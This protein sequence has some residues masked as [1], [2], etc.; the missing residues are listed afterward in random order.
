MEWPRTPGRPKS[1]TE[2][3]W[4]WPV[5]E[6]TRNIRNFCS[7]FLSIWEINVEY[8]QNEKT[9]DYQTASVQYNKGIEEG[10]SHRFWRLEGEE[11]RSQAASDPETDKTN[12]QGFWG[13]GRDKRR[14]S[15]SLKARKNRRSY[16]SWV[17]KVRKRKK[18]I[19]CL[20]WPSQAFT[21]PEKARESPEKV[22]K[23]LEKAWRR[24][25]WPSEPMRNFFFCSFWLW[26][27]A[28]S[29][30]LRAFSGLLG[31]STSPRRP[32]KLPRRP[33]KAWR[34]PFWPSEP[35]RNFFFCWKCSFIFS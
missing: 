6:L 13:L 16:F 27:H 8:G 21:E 35:M 33:E 23:R 15:S 5:T 10:V 12:F 20:L 19:P 29:G 9:D 34:R 28:F 24:P 2:P 17:R 25:F 4:C 32:K 1:F 31:P 14:F 30:L 26:F 7:Y 11:R 3:F 22:L 18:K